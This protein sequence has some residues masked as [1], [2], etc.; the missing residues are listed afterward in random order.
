M[1]HFKI[2]STAWTKHLKFRK[3]EKLFTPQS[4]KKTRLNQSQFEQVEVWIQET[5]NITIKEMGTIRKDLA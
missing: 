2:A 4:R 5:H 1:L 3:E